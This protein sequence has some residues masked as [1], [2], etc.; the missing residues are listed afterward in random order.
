MAAKKK[1]TTA[2]IETPIVEEA[3]V[4]NE[5]TVEPEVTEAPVV[6]NKVDEKPVVET[7][8]AEEK[9]EAPKVDTDV[10]ENETNVT[11]KE[12]GTNSFIPKSFAKRCFS[13]LWNGMSMD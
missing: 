4:Q 11:K 2:K 6:E 3:T 5:V 8:V 10:K 12:E 1:N 7:P 13:F 9:V